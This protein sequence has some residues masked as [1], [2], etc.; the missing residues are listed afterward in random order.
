[1]KLIKLLF[2]LVLTTTFFTA[3]TD[4]SDNEAISLNELISQYDL[5]Y[6]DYHR[7]T[8]NVDVPFVAKAFTLSFLNGTLYANNNIVD[9]GRTGN[10]LGISIGKYRAYSNILTT[11][12]DLDGTFDFEVEQIGVNEITLYDRYSDTRY[13]LIGYQRDNF[14][15]N[16]LF[17]DNIEY[18]LQEYVAWEKTDVSGGTSNAF[19]YENFLQFTPENNTTFYSSQDTNGTYI[20][21]I[22]WDFV[23]SYV[24][25]NVQ[26]IDDLKYLTLF[27]NNGDTE[28]FDLTVINDEKIRLYHVRSKTTYEY[29]GKGFV[30][31]YRSLKNEEQENKTATRNT[32]RKRTKIKR[33]TVSERNLK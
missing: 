1:M 23:G 25:K 22:N 17:Y 21:S 7:T 24:V 13:Y 20:D 2:T 32:N 9:V 8:G 6:V 27:Y 16:K 5:W 12:H 26:G 3:C 15:Y 4:Y 10:G 33:Q 28:E 29:T 19:D 11:N 30:Q 18:F 14:D 31:Y